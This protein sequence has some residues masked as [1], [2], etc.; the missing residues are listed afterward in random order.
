LL[1]SRFISAWFLYGWR[2]DRS[3][4]C[5][6]ENP[7]PRLL[8]I[9]D[10][11]G[12]T[13]LGGYYIRL[14][15]MAYKAYGDL[16]PECESRGLVWAGDSIKYVVS[17]TVSTVFQYEIRLDEIVVAD[18]NGSLRAEGAVE[19]DRPLQELYDGIY[20]P[21]PHPLERFIVPKDQEEIRLEL[22]CDWLD[23]RTARHWAAGESA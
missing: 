20:F 10:E 6:G 14:P 4:C 18:V 3:W 11:G 8:Q 15:E 7:K 9:V 2:E 21:V 17:D 13:G 19:L 16:L 22:H 12:Q 1:S 5:P 23:M